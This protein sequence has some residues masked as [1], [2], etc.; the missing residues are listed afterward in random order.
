MNSP[1]ERFLVRVW[2]KVFPQVPDF[3][4]LIAEQCRLL[5]QTWQAL[6]AFL[7]DA[8]TEHVHEVRR[9]IDS[10]RALGR[11][12]LDRLHRSFITRID[13]E[14]IYLLLTRVDHVFDYAETSMR[15]LEVLGVSADTWMKAM[16]AQLREGASAL[17]EGFVR[18]RER[19]EQAEPFAARARHA[20]REVEA[21]YRDA[22][23]ELFA[24]EGYQSATN[25]AATLS[26]REC[27]EFVVDR[28]K[29]REVYRHLS[30]AADRLAH[31]GEALHDLSV[32]YG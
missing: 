21:L 18:F 11:D 26:G 29:R 30:N 12:G 8:R 6:E 17:T 10:G 22:L 9:C 2:H 14:D 20:E 5:E 24:G 31:V 32:K 13:R 28:I 16:V 25:N 27:I 19:P 4:A 3:Q 7:D 1:K 15:E 23:A